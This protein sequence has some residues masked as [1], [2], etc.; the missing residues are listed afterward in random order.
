MPSHLKWHKRLTRKSDLLVDVVLK[1]SKTSQTNAVW[2]VRQRRLIDPDRIKHP[3]GCL[4]DGIGTAQHLQLLPRDGIRHT[5]PKIRE[6]LG[7]RS[8]L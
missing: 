4:S 3:V 2:C 5:P 7:T 6:Q 1:S 8:D